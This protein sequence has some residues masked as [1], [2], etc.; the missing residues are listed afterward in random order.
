MQSPK[1]IVT[2]LAFGIV[3]GLGCAGSKRKTQDP[4]QCMSECEQQECGYVP[5]ALGDNSEYLECLEACES[6]CSG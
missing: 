4:G 6:K 5:D 2:A 1:G 3:V